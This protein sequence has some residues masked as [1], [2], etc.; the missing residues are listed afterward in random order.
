MPKMNKIK[1]GEILTTHG[2]KGEL[3]IK[4]TGKENFNRDINYFIGN[5][6]DIVKVNSVKYHK[7]FY[8]VQFKN[9]EDINKVLKYKSQFIYI[10][11]KDLINLES[12]EYYIKDLIGLDVY[13]TNGLF[14][15][16]LTDILEYSA[17]DVYIVKTDNQEIMI[18]AVEEFIKDIDIDNKKIVVKIIEGM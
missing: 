10:D 3:K 6:Y 18:P 12:D 5:D 16:K 14:I 7:G 8:L 15:G 13:D 9:L 2:I 17:N 4:A 11:E 1:V